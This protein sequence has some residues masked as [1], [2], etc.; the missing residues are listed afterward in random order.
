MRT[1]IRLAAVGNG[2]TLL[3]GLIGGA[4]ITQAYYRKFGYDIRRG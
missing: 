3:V 4:A 1:L 2:Y